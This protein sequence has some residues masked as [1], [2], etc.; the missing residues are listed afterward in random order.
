MPP[1]APNGVFA[2]EGKKYLGKRIFSSI[3]KGW[4]KGKLRKELKVAC[5]GM[6]RERAGKRANR[7]KRGKEVLDP[8]GQE[9]KGEIE[10]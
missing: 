8:L 7:G 9:P 2:G 1:K 10:C 3:G 6:K 5:G 4:M